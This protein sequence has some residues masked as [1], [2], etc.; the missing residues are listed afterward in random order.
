MCLL[1]E[2]FFLISAGLQN[3][4]FADVIH[5][6]HAD[7]NEQTKETSHAK[8]CE[9]IKSSAL[10]RNCNTVRRSKFSVLGI[11]LT[12]FYCQQAC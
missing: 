4:R 10:S 5:F 1:I 12:I 7:Y 8:S 3:G 6:P 9:K 11:Y 2:L